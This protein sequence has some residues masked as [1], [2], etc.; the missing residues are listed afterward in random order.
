MVLSV[1]QVLRLKVLHGEYKEHSLKVADQV[2]NILKK[3]KKK[4]LKKIYFYL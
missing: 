3:R 1:I 4:R 2:E